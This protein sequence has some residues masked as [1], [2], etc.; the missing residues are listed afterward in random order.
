MARGNRHFSGLLDTGGHH[1]PLLGSSRGAWLTVAPGSFPHFLGQI[2]GMEL[3][4]HQ[5]APPGF[6][7]LP[8]KSHQSGEGLSHTGPVVWGWSIKWDKN[9]LC[10]GEGGSWQRRQTRGGGRKGRGLSGAA[11]QRRLRKPTPRPGEEGVLESHHAESRMGHPGR[12]EQGP[13]SDRGAGQTLCQVCVE[14]GSLYRPHGQT[15]E[16]LWDRRGRGSVEGAT[17]AEPH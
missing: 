9:H 1:S 16:G 13:W 15:P 8:G 10:Q 11:Q 17:W 4:G 6:L 2:T 12:W 5:Q 3:H 7:K 14:M